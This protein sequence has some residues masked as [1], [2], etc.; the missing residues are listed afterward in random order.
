MFGWLPDLL[1]G[2]PRTPRNR[3]ELFR[4]AKKQGWTI[5]RTRKG[6]VKLCPPEIKYPCVVTSGTTSDVRSVRNLMSN[7]RQSGLNI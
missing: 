1:A 6:H 3:K 5:E 2:R 7:L 4:A